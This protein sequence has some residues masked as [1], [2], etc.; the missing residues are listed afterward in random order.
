M[1]QLFTQMSMQIVP[2][3]IGIMIIFMFD[4]G[5]FEQIFFAFSTDGE[6]DRNESGLVM[7]EHFA[8]N[9]KPSLRMI[10]I[11]MC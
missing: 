9:L 5:K 2:R 7:G 10:T 11:S 8:R 3:I 6:R 4:G 1:L